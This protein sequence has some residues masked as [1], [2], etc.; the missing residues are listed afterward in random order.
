MSPPSCS[1]TT[2]AR[3]QNFLSLATHALA[4][5]VR[6]FEIDALSSSVGMRVDFDMALVVLA[7]GLFDKA[8]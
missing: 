1:P 5:A 7:S 8:R 6:S 3:P 2:R 4:D